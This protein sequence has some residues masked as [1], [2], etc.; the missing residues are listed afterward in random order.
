MQVGFLNDFFSHS[1]GQYV[2]SGYMMKKISTKKCAYL[3]VSSD[4][5]PKQLHVSHKLSN[6]CWFKGV[7]IDSALKSC[8]F[9]I[10][11]F[12]L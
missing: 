7:K 3:L 1:L 8:V 10:S 12:I 6:K 4:V 11:E 9:N 5:I 2:R